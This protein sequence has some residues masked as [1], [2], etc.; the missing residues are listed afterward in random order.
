MA[1]VIGILALV[2]FLAAIVVSLKVFGRPI[3]QIFTTIMLPL[4]GM[5]SLGECGNWACIGWDEIRHT[6]GWWNVPFAKWWAFP[7]AFAIAFGWLI[8]I[9]CLVWHNWEC[10]TEMWQSMEASYANRQKRKRIERELLD[11]A[12]N[13]RLREEEE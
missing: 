11:E 12:V 7:Y 6:S 1:K 2:A 3:P 10:V 8:A 13:R 5:E 9:G 4:M